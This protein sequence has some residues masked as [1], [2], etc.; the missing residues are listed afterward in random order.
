MLD[1][2]PD[3]HG[4]ADTLRSALARLGY[5]ERGGAFRHDEPSRRCLFLGDFI[6]GGSDSA[7]V[8]D[9]VRRMMDAGTALA[10]M[11]NHELNAI[12]FHTE[13]HDG[14]PLRRHSESN[15]RQHATFLREFPLGA[16]R[17]REAIDWMKRLPLFAEVEGCRA[18]HACWRDDVIARLRE[19]LADDR[20]TDELL[21]ASADPDT[22]FGRDVET[23]L[24]GIEVELPDGHSFKDKNGK[25]RRHVRY[26]WWMPQ[27]KTWAEAAL[28]VSDPSRLPENPLP[29]AAT[30]HGY[31]SDAPPVFFGHYWLTGEP[32]VEAR[33]ALCLD[34]SVGLD[35][36]LV[37]YGWDG[38]TPL[39]AARLSVHSHA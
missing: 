1:I 6:D 15:L 21:L 3:I 38:S 22:P 18:V 7:G 19:A 29:P 28:S 25:V 35:G 8:I 11:G 17:T 36:P 12:H 32:K 24:K 10:I 16:S 14:E 20:V 23:A 9:T 37:T 31:P 33:N 27:P 5:R 30:L 26:K 13:G 34:H 4:Q 39:D 2:I